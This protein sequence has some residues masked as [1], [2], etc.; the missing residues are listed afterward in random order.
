MLQTHRTNRPLNSSTCVSNR[1][2]KFII[3]KIKFLVSPLKSA[4]SSVFPHLCYWHFCFYL[5]KSQTLPSS[6]TSLILSHSFYTNHQQVLLA[7]SS[8]YLQTRLPDLLL[9]LDMSHSE[10]RWEKDIILGLFSQ[11]HTLR[12]SFVSKRMCMAPKRTQQYQ[13]CL[14][15]VS[16]KTKDL[17]FH[18]LASLVTS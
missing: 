3:S 2:S 13:W 12:W 1:H 6:L 8:L 18:T 5:L 10:D 4:P 14:R 16:Q 11:E 7:Q 9:I 15:I 17:G